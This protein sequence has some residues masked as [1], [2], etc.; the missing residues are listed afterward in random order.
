MFIIRASLFSCLSSCCILKKAHV[1]N[2][3]HFYSGVNIFI[4]KKNTKI[5]SH[6]SAKWSNTDQMIEIQPKDW[7]TH[8]KEQQQIPKP[9]LHPI[10]RKWSTYHRCRIAVI[11]A[12]SR[13]WLFV[14]NSNKFQHTNDREYFFPV[15]IYS[16]ILFFRN[17]KKMKIISIHLFECCEE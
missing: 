6:F 17:K 13:R 3:L 14:K 7:I 4:R 10:S 9:K 2:R 15:L 16:C 11:Y 12:L 8:E 1:K 5:C